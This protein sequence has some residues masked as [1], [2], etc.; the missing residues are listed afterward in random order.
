MS[1]IYGL[2]KIK[3]EW[4][5]LIDNTTVYRTKTRKEATDWC[6]L[7][8]R[9][10]ALYAK[11]VVEEQRQQEEKA[12]LKT[13]L[14]PFNEVWHGQKNESVAEGMKHSQGKPR[15]DLLPWDA[16]DEVAKVLTFGAR[17]YSDDNWRK[18]DP[19]E[20]EAGLL[21][22]FSEY[23]Q[24]TVVDSESGEMTLAHLACCALFMVALKKVG[25][26]E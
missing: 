14:K 2:E 26:S 8:S 5:V 24:G 15:M 22:H 20:Y 9:R 17:K 19:K 23:K 6:D 12:V 7:Q 25:K 11:K 18:V 1:Q 4:N 13:M 16:L 3:G 21:R 10:E